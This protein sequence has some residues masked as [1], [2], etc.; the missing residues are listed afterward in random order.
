M[1]REINYSAF[2][3]FPYLES[4][5]LI[6]RELSVDDANDHFLIESDEKVAK[7]MDKE[8]V[9]SVGD[10]KKNIEKLISEYNNKNAIEWVIV[11][12]GTKKYIGSIGYW[13]IIPE[14]FRAEIGYCLHPNYWGKGLMQEAMQ[15]IISFGFEVLKLHSI[16]ANVN[17]EN[18]NS[19]KL[20]EKMGFKRE[21][22][23]RE[24]FYFSNKFIDTIT[25]S[26]LEKDL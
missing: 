25:Y 9:K 15:E 4:N 24:N 5:R 1:S 21:G 2:D 20:L 13:K 3:E 17:P 7:Y 8:I 23:F 22:Y 14:H 26:L 18:Y 11:D 16:E 10:S 12:K 6:Y 19:L